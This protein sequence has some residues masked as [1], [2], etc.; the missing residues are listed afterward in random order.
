MSLRWK[1][2]LKLEIYLKAVK[3]R[4]RDRE[5]TRTRVMKD[6]SSLKSQEEKTTNLLIII[7]FI[8]GRC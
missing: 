2:N 4:E 8:L 6:I 1:N 3:R 7:A 5:Q